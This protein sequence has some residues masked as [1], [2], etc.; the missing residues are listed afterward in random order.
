M[1]EKLVK[2]GAKIVHPREKYIRSVYFMCD[3]NIKGFFRIR[4]EAG[5]VFLTAK[6]YNKDS[7]FPEE[8]ELSINEDFNKALALFNAIGLTKKALQ[9]SYREK[10]IHKLAHEITFDTI[11]GIPTYMEIDCDKEE[12]LNKLIDL[13]DLDRS[14]MRYGSFDRTYEEYYGIDR[15]TINNHTPFLTFK[16]ILKEIH[17][18]KNKQLLIKIAT[19]QKGMGLSMEDFHDD[20]RL[21]VRQLSKRKRTSRISLSKRRSYNRLL[22]LV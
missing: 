17:P 15:D 20:N 11:P 21:M 8:Y 14:K 22:E 18:T 5:K 6:T 3:R 16:G 13:L 19:E 9:E 10:W 1:K 7:N 12:K 2:I 4:D